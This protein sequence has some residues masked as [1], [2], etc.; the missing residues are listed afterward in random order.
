MSER[1][2]R[3]HFDDI[4]KYENIIEARLDPCLNIEDVI[5]DN[6][7]ILDK[8]KKGKIKYILIDED[9]CLDIKRIIE[10]E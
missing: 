3:N 7:V 2:I 4:K 5:K 1:Y 10:L 6:N 8:A 9:Y